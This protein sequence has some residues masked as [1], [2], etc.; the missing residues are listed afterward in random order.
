LRCGFWERANF[1]FSDSGFFLVGIDHDLIGGGGNAGE[2]VM[3]KRN[4][5][6]EN[7]FGG[8]VGLKKDGIFFEV[9]L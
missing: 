8:R 6:R 5:F 3:N 2:E 9:W 7:F 4:F 1:R